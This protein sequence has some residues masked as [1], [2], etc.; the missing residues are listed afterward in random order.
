VVRK[1]RSLQRVVNGLERGLVVNGISGLFS[2]MEQIS[3]QGPTIGDVV[4]DAANHVV[5]IWSTQDDQHT[6]IWVS[7]AEDERPLASVEDETPAVR[8]FVKCVHV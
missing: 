6:F 2:A 1:R 3:R 4:D 8:A 5:Q 7:L